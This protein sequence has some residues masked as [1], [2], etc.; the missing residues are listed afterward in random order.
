MRLYELIN[1]SDVSKHLKKD[2]KV[3][4]TEFDEDFEMD[5]AKASRALCKSSKPDSALG[6]SQVSSCISQGLRP[7]KGQKGAS[8]HGKWTKTRGKHVKGKKYGGPVK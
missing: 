3:V 4:E 5:E 7:H 1:E 6:A 8:I 2:I